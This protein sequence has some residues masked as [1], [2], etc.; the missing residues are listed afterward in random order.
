MNDAPVVLS[1]LAAA[2]PLTPSAHSHVPA[3]SLISPRPPAR[4]GVG[5]TDVRRSGGGRGL[6]VQPCVRAMH[7]AA[8]ERGRLAPRGGRRSGSAMTRWRARRSASG[9]LRRAPWRAFSWGGARRLVGGRIATVGRCPRG[10]ARRARAELAEESRLWRSRP[11]LARRQITTGGFGGAWAPLRR[12]G[13]V[14]AS[15]STARRELDGGAWWDRTGR[16]DLGARSRADR[17]LPA[18]SRGDGAR[19]PHSGLADR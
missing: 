16:R 9:S 6:R 14:D 13:P 11:G 15:P 8:A 19:A 7:G 1:S 10:N 18:A 17:R 5:W 2:L 12:R 3:P 4:F